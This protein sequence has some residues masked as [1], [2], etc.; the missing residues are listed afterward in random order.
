MEQALES[1]LDAIVASVPGVSSGTAVDLPYHY[2]LDAAQDVDGYRRWLASRAARLRRRDRELVE[3]LADTDSSRAPA[4][5]VLIPVFEPDPAELRACVGSL[6]TQLHP[7]AAICLANDAPHHAGTVALLEELAASH[8]SISVVTTSG[9]TGIAAATNAAAER[10]QG[11]FVAFVDQDDVL[12]AAALAEVAV[13]VLDQPDADVLYS[14][15]DKLEPDGQ[16]S[17]PYFKPGWSPDLLLSNMYLGHL[18]VVRRSL[19]VELGGLRPDYDGSQDHDL[20][21]RSTERA[22]A[23]VHIPRVLYHWRKSTGSTAAVH[24]AKPYAHTAAQRALE[25]AMRRRG[26]DADVGPGLHPTTWRVRRRVAGRPKVSIVVPFH[27]GAGLLRRC[28]DSLRDTAGHDHWEAL[29]VDNRSWQPETLALL[30]YLQADERCRVLTY[31][32]PFNWSAINNWAA[33][34]ATGEHLLFLN[35]DVEG[36]GDGWLAA[37][38]EHAQRPEVGVVG[39]RLLYPNLSVQHAGIVMG[40]GGGVA[41]HAFCFAPPGC[42][43]YFGHAMVTRNY[44][45]VTGACMLVPRPVFDRVGGFDESLATAF[46]DVDFCLRVR[47][48]GLLVVYTPYAE[49]IH[50]EGASRGVGAHEATETRMMFDRWERQIRRDPYF[51]PDLDPF[52]SEFSLRIDLEDDDPWQKVLEAVATSS[53]DSAET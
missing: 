19:F 42:P 10:A 1:L 39:A 52:R 51:N 5:S 20:A 3:R 14:D 33:A 22:R 27:D 9:R 34:Q 4:V 28:Y 2:G 49:L 44:T 50:Y 18:L 30:P 26:E 7:P 25:D 53:S 35:S 6:T 17:E 15:E 38:L 45:A 48:A 12:D 23:V 11:D 32:Q 21:L 31:D 8:P 29:F 41:W 46:N 24:D 36:R 16:R 43:G 13:A 47:E 40:M 37:M